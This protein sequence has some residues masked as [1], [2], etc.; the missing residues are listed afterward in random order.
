MH[1]L[2]LSAFY[3]DSAAALLRDGE[4]VAA[5][6]EERFTRKKH[7][8]SFPAHAVRYCL[9]AAGISAEELDFVGFYE[10]PLTKFDRLLETYLAYAPAGYASFREALPLWLG[11][12]LHLPR[13]LDR[14]LGA[15]ERRRYV[16]PE[17]HES[18]AASAFFPS[19]F[20][21]A[22]ILTLDGVG[23]WTTGS[24]GHGRGNR[25]EISHELRFPH[26]LGLLYSAFTSYTGFEINDGE[27]KLMGLAPYG[28]PLYKAAI[29]EH[30]I[31]VKEDGSFWMDMA[32][33]RY[34]Q[35]LVMTSEAF[36]RVFGGPPRRPDE[37]IR[38]RHMDLARSVQ[39]VAEEVILKIARHVRR[40]T[41]SRNLCLAGG[42]AL[43]CVANGILA[44]DGAFEKIWVQP[45]AGDAGGALGTALLVW[46]QL[47]GNE[48]RAQAG[49]AQRGSLLGPSFSQRE[50]TTYL[51]SVG[52]RYEVHD[53]ESALLDRV[54]GLLAE[55]RVVGWFHG[56]MEFGPRA[57]GS[58]S[59]L[60]D[61]RSP[62]MQ[63]A[64]NLKVKFRESFR[65]FA[66]CV[67]REH[68]AA[69]FAMEPDQESPY[70]LFVAPVKDEH[71]LA[72]DEDETLRSGIERLKL[73]RS[74]IPAVTHV[75]Y[76]ARV[77]TV[78]AE[79][80]GRFR[81]LLERFHAQTGCPIL[82]NTSFNLSW[83]P[84]VHRPEEAYHTF[85]QSD[86]DVL[87]LENAVLVKDAQR[88]KRDERRALAAGGERDPALEELWRCPACG[89]EL[90]REGESAH[91]SS[92]PAVFA[93]EDGIWQL[94]W[95]HTRG[96]GD[97]TERVKDFY[98]EHPFP[99]YDEHESL[100]SLIS[101]SR[102]GHYARMLGD[103]IPY[104]S[105]VLEV[106][107]GTGQLSNFLAIGCRTVVGTDLCMNSLRLAEK[108]R[109]EHGLARARFLQM[110][111]FRPALASEHFDVVLCNGVLHHTSDPFGGFRSIAALVRP[112]GHIVVGLYNR[113]GR[114]LRDAREKLF[115]ASGGRLR[116]IDPYLRKPGV[117]AA[118][119]DAW[120]ADQ[121]LHPHE[122]KH[123][124]GEVLDWF[125][126]TGF[127][128][129]NA[130]PKTRFEGGFSPQEQLFEPSAR[131]SATDRALAQARLVFTGSREG[132]FFV[133]IGRKR[134]AT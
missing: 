76:S 6:Q 54:A 31:D 131:G 49:D 111:L 24:F 3:H 116:W 5:A 89:G 7:D 64:I 94:F 39:E 126:Q 65:P 29:Y 77:Q 80:H 99:N 87:V 95:T 14:G 107:C 82:V 22:A 32:Y 72:L 78:D 113:F 8:S 42:V 26:S 67:L 50:I 10:K 37:P 62:R 74:A 85:M 27:Y 122:S 45:A 51:D 114:L 119:R 75:D 91:C 44:R 97:I 70:M 47:L 124:M 100:R 93:R 105:R 96:A 83:E 19:P 92:C 102:Q 98:E 58:R 81:R 120:Y 2:G 101:K 43:N 57:L 18:H 69:Y 60:G 35:G 73:P 112:S 13:E 66:P 56:R 134:A 125:D 36:E 34:C 25:L 28:R 130:M 16:F 106:G 33:F 109:S 115:K 86:I 104:N 59:I 128:F 41:G 21:E 15:R 48:R 30:L 103:Q 4:I 132:G 118:K 17:H 117:S 11:K 71:R 20:D 38:Q 133:M 127:D 63:S 90:A 123:T 9:E 68:A 40:E 108:F 121:Y 52:A 84:I 55:G 79:R 88:A 46:Y 110:N 129:V 61:P 53:E 1:V 23:E 12:K